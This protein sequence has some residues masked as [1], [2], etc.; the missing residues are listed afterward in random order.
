MVVL[1]L[2]SPAP[3]PFTLP[4]LPTFHLARPPLL[5]PVHLS[6]CPSTS[7]LARPPFLLFVYLSFYPSTSPLAHPPLLFLVYPPLALHNPSYTHTLSI[8]ITFKPTQIQILRGITPD[9]LKYHKI[10]FTV[11]SQN[12]QSYDDCTFSFSGWSPQFPDHHHPV[13]DCRR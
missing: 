7:P 5:L 8:H 11:I 1:S 9:D 10:T 4:V 13:S 6:S 3:A 12:P 2:P